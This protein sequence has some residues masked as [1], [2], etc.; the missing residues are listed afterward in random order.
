MMLNNLPKWVFIIFSNINRLPYADKNGTLYL[1]T[2]KEKADEEIQQSPY[3]DCLYIQPISQCELNEAINEY[4]CAGYSYLIID[5]K[6]KTVLKDIAQLNQSIYFSKE[7]CS[8]I[9]HNNQLRAFFSSRAAKDNRE[10]NDKE[11]ALLDWYT[12]S[13][14]KKLEYEQ[15]SLLVSDKIRGILQKRKH[16]QVKHPVKGTSGVFF[17]I[18]AFNNKKYIAF[19]TDSYAFKKHFGQQI[20]PLSIRPFQ[21]AVSFLN[22]HLDVS[23]IIINPGRENFSICRDIVL[24]N[25][26]DRYR[27]KEKYCWQCGNMLNEKMSVC[28][29]CN[30]SVLFDDTVILHQTC[31]ICGEEWAIQMKYC[32]Y[33]GTAMKEKETVTLYSAAAKVLTVDES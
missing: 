1:F 23:G 6:K 32:P 25:H 3:M 12:L 30:A 13:I 18:V 14:I 29:K 19:F 28:P 9:I 15:E 24:Y 4:Y 11:Y 10:L 27:I 33:C 17:P 21:K 16:S 31:P 7:L 20:K 8:K 5:N 26:N 2:Q 22:K